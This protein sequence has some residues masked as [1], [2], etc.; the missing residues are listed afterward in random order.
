MH[1]GTV[2]LLPSMLLVGLN[3][4][5]YVLL[6]TFFPLTQQGQDTEVGVQQKQ[7]TVLQIIDPSTDLPIL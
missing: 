2:A 5:L 3:L 1:L 6:S 4:R 7:R